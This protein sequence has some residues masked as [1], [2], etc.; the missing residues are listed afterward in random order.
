MFDMFDPLALTKEGR[1]LEQNNIIVDYQLWEDFCK[2][3]V[4]ASAALPDLEEVESIPKLLELV[5]VGSKKLEDALDQ[6]DQLQASKDRLALR[7]L[8]ANVKVGGAEQQRDELAAA[9]RQFIELL[10]KW[11]VGGIGFWPEKELEELEAAIKRA[12][13]S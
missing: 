1:D 3:W 8:D 11:L 9:A 13:E 7:L 4:K 12:G 6:R 5:A 2:A 10:D